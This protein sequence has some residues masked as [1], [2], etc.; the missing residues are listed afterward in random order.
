MADICKNSTSS[1][2]KLSTPKRMGF[3]ITWSINPSI[4]VIIS[5]RKIFCYISLFSGIFNPE[6][7]WLTTKEAA[8]NI[9]N[10]NTMINSNSYLFLNFV[11]NDIEALY[12]KT[13]RIFTSDVQN[14]IITFSLITRDD[15]NASNENKRIIQRSK[16]W[17]KK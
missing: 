14:Y 9:N 13:N 1:E 4:V 7:E 3:F 10:K 15:K 12:C 11:N 5:M 6:S 17:T 8:Q 2:I 16:Q